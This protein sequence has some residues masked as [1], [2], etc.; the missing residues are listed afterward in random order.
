[1]SA[2]GHKRT[3]AVQVGMSALCQ[4]RTRTDIAKVIVKEIVK[5]FDQRAT[6]ANGW[7]CIRRTR[8]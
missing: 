8:R 2:F 1:M 3:F 5:P 7:S 4:K 6:E